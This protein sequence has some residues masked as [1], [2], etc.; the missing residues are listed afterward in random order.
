MAKVTGP[1]MSIDAAGT[2]FKTL[3]AS[4]SKGRNYIKGYSKP[5]YTNTTLQ[6][7]QRALMAA[8]V[9]EWQG[10]AAVPPEVDPLGDELY[11][12]K[13][14]EFGATCVRPI[15][16]Y[17]AFVKTYIAEGTGPT[18]PTAPYIGPTGIHR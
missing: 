15:S 7:A 4:I 5:T 2:I 18:I 11:K 1:F 6:A 17:N 3:T 16:G 12:S 8:A 10:L 14:N 13:W 9:L